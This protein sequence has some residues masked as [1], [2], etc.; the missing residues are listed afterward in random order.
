ML[1][2]LAT[3]HIQLNFNKKYPKFDPMKVRLKMG[4]M[5]SIL[6]IVVT[7]VEHGLLFN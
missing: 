4:T 3:N 6:A 7:R 1:L 2:G 5:K